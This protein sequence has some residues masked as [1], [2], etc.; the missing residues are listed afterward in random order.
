MKRLLSTTG[1]V[2]TL[3]VLA[4]CSTADDPA[5]KTS[6][7]GNAIAANTVMQMVDPWPE[8]VD[9]TNLKTPAE[10]PQKKTDETP[11]NTGNKTTE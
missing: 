2:G 5:V 1:L 11:T 8:G 7:L 10:H 9:D 6:S 3:A 4:A